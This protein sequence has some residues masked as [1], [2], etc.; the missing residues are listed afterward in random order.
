MS[1]PRPLEPPGCSQGHCLAEYG[2]LRGLLLLNVVADQAQA[3]MVT[4]APRRSSC[5]TFGSRCRHRALPDGEHRGEGVNPALN[6]SSLSSKR[7]GRCGGDSLRPAPGRQGMDAGGR[8][9]G[10]GSGLAEGGARRG[11]LTAANRGSAPERRCT[12]FEGR[13]EEG[14]C[15]AA[16]AVAFRR[17]PGRGDHDHSLP[18]GAGPDEAAAARGGGADPGR[19][20]RGACRRR[21][22]SCST[23]PRP[24]S[25]SGATTT[26]ARCSGR[27]EAS[28]GFHRW[29][30]AT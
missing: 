22:V 4:H 9:Y 3:G 8:V 21:T 17:S 29:C 24:S 5:V 18:D 23:T 19:A 15:V 10:G 26:R 28:A 16:R 1:L 14:T 27:S 30:G 25:R 13:V 2:C 12:D 7:W 11:Q 6:T 20:R